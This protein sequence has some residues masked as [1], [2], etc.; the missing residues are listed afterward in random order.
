MMSRHLSQSHLAVPRPSRRAIDH[1]YDDVYLQ[2]WTHGASRQY[3]VVALNGKTVRPISDP[4]AH[5]HLQALEVRERSQL[6]AEQTIPAAV[7]EMGVSSFEIT[8]PWMDR[9]G[10]DITYRGV[11]RD[12]L[13]NLTD[14][15]YAYTCQMGHVLCQQPGEADLVSSA[16]DEQKLRYLLENGQVRDGCN[17][18]EVP[19]VSS[20][21]TFAR[22]L[23]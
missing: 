9:T 20:G 16:A 8:R 14:T 3:W 10:W 23:Y 1:L 5:E 11:R 2:S 6:A 4:A 13:Q 22:V 15:P 7:E 18:I 12:L 19:V 21:H 17:P